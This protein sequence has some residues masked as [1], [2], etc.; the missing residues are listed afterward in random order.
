[1]KRNP[2][3]PDEGPGQNLRNALQGLQFLK[4]QMNE[5]RTIHGEAMI[6]SWVAD[7]IAVENRVKVALAQVE[8]GRLG[9]PPLMILSNPPFKL[10]HKYRNMSGPIKL[11]GEISGE[12]HAILYRHSDDSEP[13]RHDFEHD[14]TMLAVERA[15]KCDL[16]ITSPDGH[17][18]WQDF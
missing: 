4:M 7:V 18:I 13:Y 9:N 8:G 2:A 11:V 3:Q 10:S 16:L 17:P 14:T 1:M 12:V 15:G 5:R 6:A